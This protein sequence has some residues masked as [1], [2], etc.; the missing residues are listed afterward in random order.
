M[1][2]IDP[3]D[4]GHSEDPLSFDGPPDAGG[5]DLEEGWMYGVVR[6]FDELVTT[7]GALKTFTLLSEEA[8][9]AIREYIL[10]KY[11]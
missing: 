7:H 2:S 8:Q 5:F 10:D 1:T 3:W 6:D 4:L 11:N 9:V